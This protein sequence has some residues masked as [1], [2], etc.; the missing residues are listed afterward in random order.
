MNTNW[1]FGVVAA[2][3]LGG[4][5][6][7]PP[8]KYDYTAFRQAKPRS[9]VVLPPLNES[10]DV[11]ATSSVL[12]QLTHP[13][14]E[15]GYYVFPVTLVRETFHQN[16]LDVAGDI[17]TVGADKLS[18]VFGADAALYVT[19]SRYGTTYIVVDS[20]TTVAVSARLVDLKS[21]TVLWS[22]AASASSN[23]NS[24]NNSGGLVGALVAAAVKQII[25]QSTNAGYSMAGT[26]SER[27]LAGGRQNGILY[28][29]YSPK[30]GT[31]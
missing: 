13:L 21:G 14:A 30:Y 12:S 16:G 2:L 11:E 4:C 1:I 23:E 8:A 19:V 7:K 9:I 31:D 24:N 29:P 28:G 6:V 22:G 18:Q 3:A 27:L 5:A 26:A 15:A 25:N 10:P 20:V 17:Q